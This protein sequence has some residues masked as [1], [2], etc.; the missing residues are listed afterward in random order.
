MGVVGCSIYILT[1]LS[2]CI[3]SFSY[4]LNLRYETPLL[5]MSAIETRIA[6]PIVLLSSSIV[7]TPPAKIHIY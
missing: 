5:Q 2:G 6:G 7:R 4:R 3:K 1:I